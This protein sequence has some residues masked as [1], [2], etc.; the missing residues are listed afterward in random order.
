VGSIPASRTNCF[1]EN[2]SEEILGHFS[3]ARH[4]LRRVRASEQIRTTSTRQY[5]VAAVTFFILFNKTR[6]T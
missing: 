4:F 6:L 5:H 2:G 3:F 1:K